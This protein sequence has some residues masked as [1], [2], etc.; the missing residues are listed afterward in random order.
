MREA[1]TCQTK[2]LTKSKHAAKIK[3]SIPMR[4]LK[5]KVGE[6]SAWGWRMTDL[7]KVSATQTVDMN[8][9]LQYIIISWT[10]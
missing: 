2:E 4:G 7:H 9:I 6:Q 8:E 5:S 3:I 1:T 10:E